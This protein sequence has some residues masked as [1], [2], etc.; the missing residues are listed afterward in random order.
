MELRGTRECQSCGTQWSYYETGEL[1]CP[2]CGSMRSLGIDEPTEHTA[3]RAELDLSDIRHDVDSESV[4]TLANRAGAE[5]RDYL[6]SV[7]FVHAG[8]LQ[9]LEGTPLAASELRRVAAT[10]GRVMRLEDDEE[11]YFL[12][13][14]RVADQ[15]ERPDPSEIPETLYP[16]R[17]L[18]VASMLDIYLNDIRRVYEQREQD[19][20]SILSSVKS[21][22]KRIEALDGDVGPAEAERLVQTVRDLS[23]YL[24]EDDETALARALERIETAEE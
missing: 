6:R 15:N 19:V 5:T 23:A 2:D 9:P 11:L 7:G 21:R 16:E 13:L 14:L 12:E 4:Q 18:A 22:R 3:G 17:G 24:R 10:L 8:E 1:T 20:D